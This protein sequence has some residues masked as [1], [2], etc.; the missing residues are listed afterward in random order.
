[1]HRI[2]NIKAITYNVTNFVK[3]H[4]LPDTFEGNIRRNIEISYDF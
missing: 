1:M 2:E 3:F 4:I